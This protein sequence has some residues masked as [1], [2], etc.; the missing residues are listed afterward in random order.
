MAF[1]RKPGKRMRKL[2]WLF[3]S[4]MVL[5]LLS[6]IG[7][8]TIVLGGRFVVDD[9][10]FILSESTVLQTEDEEEVVKL[11]NENRTYVPLEAIPDHVTDAF[12]AIEDHRF[13]DHSGVDFWAVTRAVYRD[14]I[15]WSKAEG[16]S[17]IT[18]QLVKNVSLTNDKSWLRKTKEVMGA[19]H[20][21]RE[22][23]KDEILE[24]YLNEI[25]FG[26][27]VHGVEEAAQT[28]FSKSVGDLTISEGA[29]LAAMPKAPNYYSPLADE[30]RALER[31]NVVLSRMYDL[32]MIDAEK[33]HQ[34]RGKTLGLNYGEN[35]KNPW[36]NSYVDLVLD[37]LEESFH[38]SREEIY[39]GGYEITVALD[40]EAQETV[41]EEMQQDEYFLGSQEN[42]EGAVVMLD[43]QTGAIKAALGGRSY[44]RGDL[45]RINVKRQPGSTLKPFVVYGPAMDE[46]LYRPHDLLQ[47][48]LV[49]YDDYTPKNFDGQYDGEVTM[50]DALRLSKN[51]PAVAV[52]DE[53]GVATGKGYI[54]RAG[55]DFEDDGLSVALGGL[56]EGLTPLELA[57]LY[58]TLYDGGI[59]KEPYAI[60]QV[61]DRNGDVLEQPELNEERVFS[62]Q[63]A[64]D[65]TR[66][67]E[68]V[69]TDGTGNHGEYNKSLAGK[70][71]S[72]QH[73]NREDGARDTWF[74]GFNPAYTIATWAGY[75]QTDDSHYLTGGSAAPTA[76][77]K[78]ILSSLD[79]QQ[80]FQTAFDQ[81]ENVDD[82][83]EPIELPKITDLRA[84]ISLGFLDGLFVEL[85]WSGI[86]DERVEYHVYRDVGGEVDRVGEVSG[87]ES[88]RVK[89]VKFLDNPSYYVVPVNPLNAQTGTASNR[90]RAF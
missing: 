39:N 61:S 22:K 78:K 63:T 76:L 56:N 77:S 73:P 52:M 72:T 3:I 35:E 8:T 40:L 14:V 64:W 68:S 15:T 33:M 51:A 70:T 79:A 11:Y 31:R 67:L 90:D 5:L 53:M 45:N 81:P 37:E 28:F 66:M 2:K 32:E 17:T 41:H 89:Q 10:H 48:E 6:I 74:V 34:E 62:E 4:F 54:N 42:V 69:V 60:S 47:D 80:G 27:G 46:D 55:I 26:N 59:Y 49:S 87:Q 84:N 71:G 65:L 75:D 20:L 58:R 85:S 83:A 30:E 9:K 86:E 88:Y 50:Y 82:L 38:L 23:S 18:Q 29:M 57:S 19:I 43:Q 44:Q 21:E 7:F 12:L 24:Y 1:Q 36:L 13:Y 25:Y 16:A